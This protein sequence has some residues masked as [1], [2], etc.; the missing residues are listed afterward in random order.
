[1]KCEKC[2]GTGFISVKNEFDEDIAHPCEC[3]KEKD[4]SILLETRLI[5]A[6]IPR[7]YWGYTLDNYLSL[8]F[9]PDVKLSNKQSIERLKYFIILSSDRTF[10]ILSFSMK[11]DFPIFKNNP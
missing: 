10:I 4:A 7:R 8:P 1:M 9:S 6:S 2:K 5:D 11:K 3:R